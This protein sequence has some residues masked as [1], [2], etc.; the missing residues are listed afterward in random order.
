MVLGCFT[1]TF[2][3][4]GQAADNA[5]EAYGS[6]L[7]ELP[8]WT[9]IWG[10][11]EGLMF[12]GNAKT[13]FAEDPAQGMGGFSYGPIVGSTIVG[14]PYNDKYQAI[15]D[16]KVRL[17]REEFIIDDPLGNCMLPHGMPRVMGAAPG[18]MEFII[19]P[20]QTTFILNYMNQV[21]RIYTDGRPHP[22]ED[23]SWPTVMGHSVGHWE[24]HTLVVDS[25]NMRASVFDR[26]GAPHS[27]KVHL[28][29]RITKIDDN[30]IRNEMIVE[31]AIAFTGPWEVTR[32]YK[33][34]QGEFIDVEGIYCENQRNPIIDGNQTVVLP[35]DSE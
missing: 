30:T 22:P 7:A 9:G 13:V 16:E 3:A 28:M 14:V 32:Y 2:V 34:R 18:A 26:S 8:D 29:E 12:P 5:A 24:G 35:G 23:E 4:V 15:F 11:S 19:T 20:R 1:A 6:E 33:K 25:V 27:E 21:R 31:D 17:A 10:I